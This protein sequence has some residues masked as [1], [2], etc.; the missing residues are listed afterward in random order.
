VICTADFVEFS[1]NKNVYTC[2]PS[3]VEF[4]ARDNNR[5]RFGRS[6]PVAVTTVPQD[7]KVLLFVL[8]FAQRFSSRPVYYRL[9]SIA[10]AV[11]TV[12]HSNHSTGFPNAIRFRIVHKVQV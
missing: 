1:Q 2:I 3:A 6:I 8:I 5:K 12:V 10:A 4:R 7:P 11:E 9:R